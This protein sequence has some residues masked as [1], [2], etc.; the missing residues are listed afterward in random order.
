MS[1]SLFRSCVA[2]ALI[3][4]G[5]ASAQDCA[6]PTLAL[7]VLG[8]DGGMERGLR[9]SDLNV[10]VHGKPV[11]VS[12]ITIDKRP[13]RIALLVDTSSSMSGDSKRNPWGITLATA[14]FAVDAI[15]INSVAALA[16]F[17]Q[18]LRRESP[19][20]ESR[21]AVG[22]RVLGLK[23][24]SPYGPTALYNSLEELVDEF[25]G[26]RFGDVIYLVTDGGNT[27][28]GTRAEAV[29]VLNARG[30]RVFIFLVEMNRG[31]PTEE[32]KLGPPEME[33]MAQSTGGNLIKVSSA[34]L[35]PSQ[36]G[37]LDKLGRQI[38]D[39]AAEFYRVEVNAAPLKKAERVK[40]KL[41]DRD[42]EKNVQTVTYAREIA[43]CPQ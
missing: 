12:A 39:Q 32:E 4:C 29:R 22:D 1:A 16:I 14:A 8:R 23:E 43:G 35:V 37:A 6:P 42:R 41:V 20:F 26:L 7:N 25:A 34:Q 5:V 3:A 19:N 17:A 10:E 9:P 28:G 13:R 30:I 21:E 24:L 40:V 11:S 36:R 27:S 31:F 2:L 18:K 33:E 15:P 38:A